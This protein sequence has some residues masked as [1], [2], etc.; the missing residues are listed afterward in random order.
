[1]PS[2][3]SPCLEPFLEHPSL[4]QHSPFEP[5]P[6]QPPA[7]PWNIFADGSHRPHTFCITEGPR[8]GSAH[9]H[10]STLAEGTWA[11]FLSSLTLL[12]LIGKRRRMSK[13]QVQGWNNVCVEETSF[14][15]NQSPSYNASD[16]NYPLSQVLGTSCQSSYSHSC[17]PP[18]KGR[19]RH[20]IWLLFG[21]S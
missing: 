16:W 5:T 17:L 19:P 11:H 2:I 7:S 9:T 6:S 1:M 15:L 10:T 3:F 18:E 4:H 20:E 13:S 8:V 12:F 21:S 14:S